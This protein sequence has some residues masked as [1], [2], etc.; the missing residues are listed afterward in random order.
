MIRGKIIEIQIQYIHDLNREYHRDYKISLEEYE[1]RRDEA[2]WELVEFFYDYGLISQ[3]PPKEWFDYWMVEG[4]KANTRYARRMFDEGIID[5]SEIWSILNSA[6]KDAM[7][8][9]GR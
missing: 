8:K 4:E 3:L 1:R 7:D 2:W 5:K 9:W 6:M